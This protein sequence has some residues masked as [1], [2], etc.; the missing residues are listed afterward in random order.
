MPLNDQTPQ[1]VLIADETSEIKLGVSGAIPVNTPGILAAGT[2]NNTASFLKMDSSGSLVITGSTSIAGV[3]TIQ[4]DSYFRTNFGQIRTVNPW[5]LTD[6]INK[7]GFDLYEYASS[8]VGGGTITSVVSQS[9]IRLGVGAG[10][11]DSARVR[12]NTYYRH[13]AGKEQIIKL[14]CYHESQLVSNQVR[15]WGY[16]D[17]S[18]GFFYATSGSNFGIYRRS[19]AIGGTIDTFITQSAWNVDKF[20]GTG[21]SGVLLDL[22]KSN[23]YEIHFDWLGVGTA[24]FYI[25]GKFVH[26]LLNANT[27]AGP[28]MG[29]ATLPVALEV[30]NTAASTTS[31]LIFICTSVEAQGGQEPPKYVYGTYNAADVSVS[32]TETAILAIRPGLTYRSLEN[33][34]LTIPELFSVSTEGSRAGY[35]IILNP[36]IT[37]GTWTSASLNNSSVEVNATVTTFTGGDTIFRGFLPNS[38][39]AKEINLSDLFQENAIKLRVNGFAT[40]QDVLLV[41][42]INEAAGTT[43]MR[44]SI[45]WREVR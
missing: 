33:R 7:Y 11:T 39:D 41:T 38:N 45:T 19:S 23:I 5:T 15:R 10:S 37:G 44:A 22:R 20:D 16:F 18:N 25:N 40:S 24:E 21:Q 30:Q 34:V 13:Q 14:T 8:S 12:T 1:V 32:T 27:F 29:T 36:T 28:Y 26:Q 9:A 17:D 2:F 43:N 3:P 4:I 6:N 42:G 35:R 31:G